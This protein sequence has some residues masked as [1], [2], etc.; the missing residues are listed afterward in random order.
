MRRPIIRQTKEPSREERKRTGLAFGVRNLL[1]RPLH[2]TCHQRVV[3]RQ[4]HQLNSAKNY[5]A[6]NSK[7]HPGLSGLWKLASTANYTVQNYWPR[8]AVPG[9][10]GRMARNVRPARRPG[11]EKSGDT[12]EPSRTN[13]RE[14]SCRGLRRQVRQAILGSPRPHRKDPHD[15]TQDPASACRRGFVAI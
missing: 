3:W 15:R 4:A 7:H 2:L 14:A 10:G 9:N 1:T 8:A 5:E 12:G 6:T 13:Y 11:F